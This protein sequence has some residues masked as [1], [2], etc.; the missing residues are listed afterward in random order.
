MPTENAN[1]DMTHAAESHAAESHAADAEDALERAPETWPARAAALAATAAAYNA[2]LTKVQ[3]APALDPAPPDD[4]APAPVALAVRVTARPVG[5]GR[6]LFVELDYNHRLALRRRALPASG[7]VL[8]C[9][10]PHGAGGLAVH[11]SAHGCAL[12]GPAARVWGAEEPACVSVAVGADSVQLRFA[13]YEVDA[14]AME[15]LLGEAT[16]EDVAGLLALASVPASAPASFAAARAAHA[17]ARALVHELEFMRVRPRDDEEHAVRAD[18]RAESQAV[19][20]ALAPLAAAVPT[21]PLAPALLALFS[22]DEVREANGEHLWVAAESFRTCAPPALPAPDTAA[23]GEEVARVVR[24]ASAR[25]LG[26]LAGLAADASR[27][28]ADESE[29]QAFIDN[30]QL[31]VGR[32]AG[33]LSRIHASRASPWRNVGCTRMLYVLLRAVDNAICANIAS[34]YHMGV[35]G[36]AQRTSLNAD[37][38]RARVRHAF[39]G[40]LL[41]QV[42]RSQQDEE[43]PAPPSFA[44]AVATELAELEDVLKTLP[45]NTRAIIPCV[46]RARFRDA[47]GVVAAAADARA[48]EAVA[49][50]TSR[51][52][53]IKMPLLRVATRMHFT[54]A[55]RRGDNMPRATGAFA[56]RSAA[57]G[58]ALDLYLELLHSSH[59]AYALSRAAVQFALGVL[60]ASPAMRRGDDAC[61][62]FAGSFA[63]L[64]RVFRP[65]A[66]ALVR[67][68]HDPVR[69]A[70]ADAALHL[71]NPLVAFLAQDADVFEDAPRMAL[72][73]ALAAEAAVCSKGVRSV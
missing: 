20:A 57:Y 73:L 37:A 48:H 54:Y 23:V 42:A 67:F 69:H 70:P 51:F 5:A 29:H 19:R 39:C 61:T 71:G 27:C 3:A 15:A 11:A 43:Q 1:P 58:N 9:A 8:V 16:G 35:I 66:R 41:R 21:A 24:A 2:A 46:A 32:R 50:R 47:L 45:H 55:S 53:V 34:C 33:V 28:F 4:S 64:E 25:R 14:A 60:R 63:R 52:Q 6:M 36:K 40:M 56:G 65:E 10:L 7:E 72:N 12:H 68:V 22:D 62:D 18:T 17:A 30:N 59:D 26:G 31:L 44:A 13:P 49:A 38:D